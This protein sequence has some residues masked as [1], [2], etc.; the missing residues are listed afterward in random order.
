M[1]LPCQHVFCGGCWNAWVQRCRDCSTSLACPACRQSCRGNDVT[2]ISDRIRPHA[3]KRA[4]ATAQPAATE[5]VAHTGR[6]GS[7]M[8]RPPDIDGSAGQHSTASA[9]DTE[10][11]GQW[12]ASTSWSCHNLSN[13]LEILS[14]QRIQ[15]LDAQGGWAYGYTIALADKL[16]WFPRFLL[17]QKALTPDP[18]PLSGQSVRLIRN[19]LKSD[20]PS[21][22]YLSA[23]FDDEVQIKYQDE[24]L[25][26]CYGSTS[27]GRMGW[28]PEAI[29]APIP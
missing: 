12:I 20:H 29:C 27:D 2:K 4:Q 25:H 26:W 14:G 22:G 15:V 10:I 8:D 6:P 9:H 13:V 28:L 21:G 11:L 7:S 3:Q 5:K 19:Y 17:K 1:M 24:D 16:G 18:R 23:S